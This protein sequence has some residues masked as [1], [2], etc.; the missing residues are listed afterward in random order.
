MAYLNT[1]PPY[2]ERSLKRCK[3]MLRSMIEKSFDFVLKID[4]FGVK[5]EIVL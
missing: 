3:L 5:S 1:R 2:I 4:S